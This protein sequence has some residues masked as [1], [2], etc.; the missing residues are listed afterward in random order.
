MNQ[1]LLLVILVL[2]GSGRDIETKEDPF[3]VLEEN[4]IRF[5]REGLWN[6]NQGY[7]PGPGR[8]TDT[9]VAMTEQ[10]LGSCR[11]SVVFCPPDRSEDNS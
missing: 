7:G 1:A 4:W 2:K 9:N 11:L 6:F 3:L 8:S 10:R 5:W